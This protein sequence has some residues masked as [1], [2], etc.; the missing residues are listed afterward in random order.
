MPPDHKLSDVCR[1]RVSFSLAAAVTFLA[2]GLGFYALY[3]RRF[4]D[5]AYL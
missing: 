2:L 1:E 3:G 5:E 4:L